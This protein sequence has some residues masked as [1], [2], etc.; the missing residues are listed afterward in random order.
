MKPDRLNLPIQGMHCAACAAR[1]EKNLK[2]L[3]GVDA[4]VNFASETAQVGLGDASVAEVLEAIRQSGFSVP[5]QALS[6]SLGGMHCAACALRIEKLLLRQPGVK[7]QVNFA[8]ETAQI[9]FPAGSSSVPALISLI[10]QA[11]FKASEQ[12][13]AGTDDLAI[14][15]KAA[16]RWLILA[17]LLALPF[18]LQMLAMT[19]GWHQ[20]ELSLGWQWG[21]ATV[22]Q[23]A[24]GWRFYR[25]AWQALRG[26]SANMDVLIVLGTSAAYFYS[27]WAA[28][29]A[30]HMPEVYFEA[31]S[32]VIVLVMLGKYL[33]GR[34]KNKAGSAIAALMRLAPAIA[35]VERNGL[36][37]DL[38][39]SQLREGDLVWVREGESVPVDGEVL[40]GQAAL[41][42]SMLTGESLPV[43]KQPGDRVYAATRNQSG[44]LKIR[45]EGL[46]ESTRLARIVRLVRDAQGSRAP[47]Q[48][49]ADT[50][51]GIFVPVVLLLSLLTLLLSGWLGGNWVHAMMRAVAVL[52]I[53]CP[54]ALGLATPAAV[55]VGMG[56]GARRGILFAQ[57]TALEQAGRI[58][59]L[60]LD[61]TGTL[62][63]GHPVVT[64]IQLFS[65][66]EAGL[67]LLAGSAESGSTHP[68]ARAI[69]AHAAQGAIALQMPLRFAEFV[70]SGVEAQLDGLGVVR[71]GT[72]AWL[73]IQDHP[74]VQVWSAEG[75]TV[76]AVAV[77]G[78]VIGL[79]ALA[80]PLRPSSR[81]AVASLERL[82]VQVIMLTGDHPGAA[83]RIAREA[84]ISMFRAQLHPEDKAAAISAL[85]QQG[86]RVAM[87]GDGI[88][89]APALAAAD[90][91]IAMGG[92]AEVAIEAAAI[93]LMHNDL[94]HLADAI[95]LSQATLRKIRQN[96][97]FAFAYNCLGIPLA[98]LGWLSPALAATAMA[99]SSLS[100]VGNALLLKRWK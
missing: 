19:L 30:A 67:L 17:G 75:K 48:R 88:N 59:L 93:T 82:G 73:G 99:A 85:R 25:G 54:C 14:A 22:L 9:S 96:L 12:G 2:R 80:D 23:F 18:L 44:L 42:E 32:M 55:M 92:G 41:D 72:P 64:D 29:S 33:E 77:D 68:L 40:E 5:E 7:A 84:G 89:D 1:L 60:A 34:A 39:V 61:K 31:S 51:S 52:V 35:R 36:Q 70:G 10:E 79:L 47:I 69:V 4:Q 62:T 11:G 63:E 100:V 20:L 13:A 24:F 28:L 98:A 27:C 26:G 45:T 74:R 16:V 76:I 38:P 49:L 46:G 81:E 57:A 90:V 50:V 87:A 65:G 3:P 86:Y 43:D 56:N 91:G 6:L 94:L 71:V 15:P 97:F 58:T 8:S 53:A 37:Q 83:E 66:D 21:L 95:R 78:L